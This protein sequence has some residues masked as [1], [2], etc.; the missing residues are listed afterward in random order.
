MFLTYCT[1]EF[2]WLCL[3]VRDLRTSR[4]PLDPHFEESSL[5]VTLNYLYQFIF[6][7]LNG[8]CFS[9]ITVDGL[10]SYH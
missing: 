3:S 1:F 4:I 6:W 8:T 10:I 5:D 2:C 9:Y 7:E